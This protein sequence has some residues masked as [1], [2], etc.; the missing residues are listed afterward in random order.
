[1]P[2]KRSDAHGTAKIQVIKGVTTLK[3]KTGRRASFYVLK[4]FKTDP[5]VAKLGI[6]LLG[7]KGQQYHVAVNGDR[8][9]CDCPDHTFRPI[10]RCKHLLALK[11]CGY[12]EDEDEQAEAPPPF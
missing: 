5:K 2:G 1:M 4:Q 6:L 10:G 12:I 9:T 8:S 11:A 7:N 3:I